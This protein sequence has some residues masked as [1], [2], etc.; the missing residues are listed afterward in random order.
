MDSYSESGR[1]MY[2]ACKKQKVYAE[3]C[4]E[5]LGKDAMGNQP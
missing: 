3:L 4:L 2:H 5:I 1:V